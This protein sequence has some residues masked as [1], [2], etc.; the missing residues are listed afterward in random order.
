MLGKDEN[1]YTTKCI[2]QTLSS[3][4]S[5]KLPFEYEVLNNGYGGIL[6]H[7][8]IQYNSDRLVVRASDLAVSVLGLL[9]LHASTNKIVISIHN[10]TVDNNSNSDG[11]VIV[12]LQNANYELKKDEMSDPQYVIRKVDELL[13]S[14]KVH[15][16]STFGIDSIRRDFWI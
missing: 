4:K 9:D 7:V 6:V 15:F 13:G 8:E 1:P 16:D 14:L 11:G 2:K 10:S 12:R 3:S 5:D